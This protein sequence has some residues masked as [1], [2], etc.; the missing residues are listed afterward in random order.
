[1][2]RRPRRRRAGAVRRG[3]ALRSTTSRPYYP[4]RAGIL[5]RVAGDVFAVDGVS[6]DIHRGETLGLV[7]RSGCGKTTLGR[8]LLNLERATGGSVEARRQGDPRVRRSRQHDRPAADADRV[9]GPGRVAEPADAGQRHHRRGAARPATRRTDGASGRV[10]T[11]ASATTSRS[12]A[13]GA[14]MRAAIRTSSPAASGSGSGS[15]GARARA[16]ISSSP[17]N[18]S[19]PWTCRSSP[20]CSTCCSTFATSSISRTCSSPTTCRSSGYISDRV[21]S[22]TWGTRRARRRSTTVPAPEAPVHDRPAVGG[23]GPDPRIRKPRLVLQGDVPSP[24]APPSGCRFHT[25]LLAPRASGQP[26]EPHTDMPVSATS[27][28]SQGGVPLGRARRGS[29]SGRRLR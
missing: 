15:R 10:A 26:E 24:A 18:R 14:T 9:P 28:R 2:T 27:T 21:G 8:T 12:S 11:S 6:F 1:M 4:I 17:T 3:H 5:R 23:A 7:G 20:R 25:R 29:P 19:P 22:C 16:R 13:C